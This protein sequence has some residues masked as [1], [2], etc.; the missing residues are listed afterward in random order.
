[1]IAA[2]VNHLWQS[3]VFAL[4]AGAFTLVFRNNRAQVR[5]WLWLSASLKFLAPFFLL[6][7]LGSH[8]VTAT[9]ARQQAPPL[10]SVAILQI[11][12]PLP[13]SPPLPEPSGSPRDWIFIASF[14]VWAFGFVSVA[15]IRVRKYR[16]IR[17]ALRAS[18]RIALPLSVEVRSSPFLLE[19]GVFGWWRPVLLLPQGIQERLTPPQFEAVLAHEICHIRRRDNLTASLHMLVEALFWFHPLVWWIGARL[20]EER[21]RACDEAVLR[22]GSAP[23]DYAEA[24]LGVCKSYLESPLQSYSGV[25]GADIRKRIHAILTG[26][27][28]RELSYIN[29]VVLAIAAMA[30]LAVPVIVGVLNAP[31]IR[32]QSAARPQFEVASLKPDNGCENQRRYGNLS[33]S[34]G[35]LEMPC[36]TLQGLVQYAWGMFR[37]GATVNVESLHIEGGPSWMQS[38]RYSLSAKAETPVRTETLAGPMLQVFLEERF[39]LKVHRETRQAPV[40]VMGVAKSGLKLQQLAEGACTPIDLTHPPAP[41]PLKPGD[42]LPN[43]CGAMILRPAGNGALVMEIRGSTMT[44]LAQRLSGSAGRTVVDKRGQFNFHLEFTPERAALGQPP[45]TGNPE[46]PSDAAPNLFVA[47]QEQIGLKLSPD[48]GP[49]GF[50]IIDHVEHPIAN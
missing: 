42:P 33:P 21:E 13:P 48:K 28:A 2:L 31:L 1:M 14:S 25:T 10:A 8:F 23:R 16:R 6:L 3:S 12:Q 46:P 5:Y 11:A 44:Q 4:A 15:L 18:I 22:T 32:A 35:R 30:A 49:V 45:F 34:P 36:V 40:Y 43:L 41:A 24:I 7:S 26:R 19:P 47:L 39:R 50:L 29:K 9:A 17:A 37:D 27:V 38:E 20:V